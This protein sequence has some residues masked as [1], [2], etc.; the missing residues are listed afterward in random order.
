MF[1][2]NTLNNRVTIG[3]GGGTPTLFVLDT[4]NTS[5]DPT[6]VDGAEYYNSNTSEFR[7]Y[8]GGTWRT[9]GGLAAS[10]TGDIQFRNVDGSLYKPARNTTFCFGAV[11]S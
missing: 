11:L 10:S 9:C 8:S 5:G 1:A 2:L 7:C 3:T 4:K 6:G